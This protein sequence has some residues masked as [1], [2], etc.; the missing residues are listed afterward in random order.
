MEE[1]KEKL[2]LD[3]IE[4]RKNILHAASTL[5]ARKQE[6]AFLGVWSVKDLLAHLIGWDYT[7]IQAIK[8]ILS[9]Q[10]PD[11]F[12]RYDEDWRTFNQNL[13]KR[14]KSNDF[15]QLVEVASE[16]HAGLIQLLRSTPAEEIDKDRGLRCNNFEVTIADLLET[17]LKDERKHYK[18][19][20]EFGKKE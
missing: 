5:P 13:V 18:Q 6:T 10:V 11:F 19:I 20:A 2:I 12:A 1:R 7:N 17:E 4:V 9:N 14:Y 16:S 8:E 3:L 15:T